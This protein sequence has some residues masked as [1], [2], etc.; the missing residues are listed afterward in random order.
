MS[1]DGLGWLMFACEIAGNGGGGAAAP[2][3][4]ACAPRAEDDDRGGDAGGGHDTTNTGDA[5]AGL[6]GDAVDEAGSAEATAPEIALE[7]AS[8]ATSEVSSEATSEAASGTTPA[9]TLAAVGPSNDAASRHATSVPDLLSEG[10]GTCGNSESGD[11]VVT[12][13]LDAV[14]DKAAASPAAR[15]GGGAVAGDGAL[16]QD[17]GLRATGPAIAH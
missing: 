7:S 15:G 10:S 3:S 8:E 14:G 5:G 11:E 1:G 13:K 4:S 6:R 12:A 16:P 17:K 2:L 9:A